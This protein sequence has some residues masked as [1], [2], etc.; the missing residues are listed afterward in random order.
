MEEL[1]KIILMECALYYD[2]AEHCDETIEDIA[3]SVF[4][5]HKDQLFL[6]GVVWS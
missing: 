1:I 6:H 4:N 5:K 3:N 2:S